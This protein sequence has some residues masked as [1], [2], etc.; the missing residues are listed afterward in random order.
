VVMASLPGHRLGRDSRTPSSSLASIARQ[1]EQ[2]LPVPEA[3]RF[4]AVR[5]EPPDEVTR[6]IPTSVRPPLEKGQHP[7]G[8]GP[9]VVARSGTPEVVPEH[10]SHPSDSGSGSRVPHRPVLRSSGPHEGS[11]G[12]NGAPQRHSL[13]PA[14]PAPST[15][16]SHSPTAT[17]VE[18]NPSY[19]PG[20]RPV[21]DLEL[22]LADVRRAVS[23]GEHHRA[24]TQARKVVRLARDCEERQARHC[25]SEATSLLEPLLMPQVGGSHRK[26]TLINSRVSSQGDWTPAH[27]FLLSRIEQPATIDEL[28]DISPLTRP[29]TLCFIAD[30]S[31]QGIVRIE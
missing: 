14:E 28:L 5:P 27:F 6:T 16:R 24:A 26:V 29:E 22:A 31:G 7:T 13:R 3:R 4:D 11:T 1:F 17:V 21:G 12:S 19:P 10:A 20:K 18:R 8:S 25:L 15:V 23:F 2:S 30:L 9:R